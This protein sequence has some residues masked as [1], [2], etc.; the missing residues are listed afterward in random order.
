LQCWLRQLEGGVDAGEEGVVLQ[1]R[2]EGVPHRDHHTI[3][4]SGFD[5]ATFRLQRR[6]CE[7]ESWVVRAKES[8]VL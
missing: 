3:A 1:A 2:R 7:L 8:L 4:A 6:V 5:L